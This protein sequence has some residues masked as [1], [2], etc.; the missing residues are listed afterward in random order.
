MKAN[1]PLMVG[2]LDV[3]SGKVFNRLDLKI[4]MAMAR[5]D[6]VEVLEK[7]IF[8]V[9]G[10]ELQS[11]VHLRE[12]LTDHA[13]FLWLVGRKLAQF[14]SR[15]AE[16]A[17]IFQQAASEGKQLCLIGVPV[18]GIP[19]AQAASMVSQGES[20]YFGDQPICFRLMRQELKKHGADKAWING[21]PGK[22]HFYC[23]IDNA[24]T[25]GT[26][27]LSAHRKA[28]ESGYPAMLSTV[29]VNR[30]QGG[31][32]ELGRNGINV[33]S[34]YNLLDLI[35]AFGKLDLWPEGK[36]AKIKQEIQG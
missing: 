27:L 11:Y 6:S 8:G 29:L 20:V 9:S 19:L 7:S 22:H 30:Q 16:T 5:H 14:F 34:V 12:D 13:D 10:I 15:L 26:S 35:Y 28:E 2:S 21:R 32:G 3:P 33:F 24:I 17:E 1:M 23:L 4:A 18:A 36:I 25:T 31:L